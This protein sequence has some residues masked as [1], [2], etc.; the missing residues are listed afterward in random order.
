MNTRNPPPA[1]AD[2]AH[3]PDFRR[4]PA[5]RGRRLQLGQQLVQS[6]AWQE[7]LAD[8]VVHRAVGHVDRPSRR[9]AASRA[10]TASSAP[11]RSR[12]HWS[13]RAR[14]PDRFDSSRGNP[15]LG[16][17]HILLPAGQ[18]PG[19]STAASAT[20]AVSSTA[21]TVANTSRSASDVVG[22]AADDDGD[23]VGG[24]HGQARSRQPGRDDDVAGERDEPVEADEPQEL[25][26]RRADDP[27]RGRATS[28]RGARGSC[29]PP[30]S[31]TASGRAE[32]R[33]G[34]PA[35]TSRCRTPSWQAKPSAPTSAK[36]TGRDRVLMRASPGYAQ[37]EAGSAQERAGG[38]RAGCGQDYDADVLA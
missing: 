4:Q 15:Q 6:D 37:D 24:Q 29:A 5:P 27:R 3:R 14:R 19:S 2:H 36:I 31:A 28:I 18:R 13:R 12:R 1:S 33:R 16:R 11:A 22:D 10:A 20:P 34:G 26:L 32:R 23:D 7:H 8:P 30:P 21:E 25:R 38:C 9:D 17:L 35:P